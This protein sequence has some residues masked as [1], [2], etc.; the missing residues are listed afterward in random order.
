M[1]VSTI[2][3]NWNRHALLEGTLRSYLATVAAPFEL[4][5]ID[6]A[7]SDGSR[8]TI[9][10]CRARLP[11]LQMIFL[12]E[13]LG[14]E[15]IN[16][17]LEHVSGDLVH[18]SE[19]DQLFL[20]G[21]SQHV[22]DCFAKFDGLGQLSLHGVVP[23]D[24]E[25]WELK[26]AQSHFSKGKILYEALGSVGTCCV[27]PVHVFRAGVRVHNIPQ[28]GPESFKFPDDARLSADIKKLGFWCAWSDRYYARNI[29]HEVSEFARDL[30]YYRKNY[31]SKPWLGIEGWRKR[32]DAARSRPR[33][34]RRSMVFPTET[35]QAE[36]TERDITGKSAQLWSMF[37]GFTPEGE[38]VDFLYTLARM[39]K[40]EHA[41]ETGT[42]LGRSGVAVGSAL[43]DNGFGH[44][45]S[46]ELDPEV[47]RFAR[48][49][50][51]AAA[52]EDWVEIV[53]CHSLGFEP[54][55]ELQFALLDS[56]IGVRADEF[57]HFYDK[58]AP[59]ATVVFHDTGPQHAGLADAIKELVAEGR[60]TGSFFQTPRGIFVGS[61]QRPP[62]PPVPSFPERSLQADLINLQ[63]E[64]SERISE[65][66]R[67]RRQIDSIQASTC[68]RITWPIRWLHR[69]FNRARNVL[70]KAHHGP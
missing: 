57:R 47:S 14:G 32:L 60:L 39:V 1:R 65:S 54:Q 15:A 62:E 55:N 63:A 51:N 22:R 17:A 61:V 40:P 59:R 44:L 6:N 11:S 66:E 19:N 34:V 41:I 21:W 30:E 45:I 43:R 5:V 25:A 8:E 36:K 7:S 23:T 31:E 35:L 68:W 38:V 42:R 28:S 2:V 13:N 67:L 33:P 53:A 9:E 50:I 46:L 52:L 70:L 49:Q 16:L 4:I 20:D 69:E 29:G 24:D 37:D 26:P 10:R 58:L 64:L 48:A 56:D 18:I 12:N 27:V 3:L